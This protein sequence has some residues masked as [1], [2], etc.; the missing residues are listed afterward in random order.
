MDSM[1]SS[2]VRILQVLMEIMTW[3]YV[4]KL[5]GFMVGGRDESLL[6]R[7]GETMV[8]H[9]TLLASAAHKI[10]LPSN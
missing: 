1:H 5:E 3:F 6:L 2:N 7:G 8:E 4:G 9:S 10:R